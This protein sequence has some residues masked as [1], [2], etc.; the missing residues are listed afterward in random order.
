MLIQARFKFDILPKKQ[1]TKNKLVEFTMVAP[2]KRKTKIRTNTTKT[3]NCY[4][5]D[6]I[7]FPHSIPLLT[8]R[9]VTAPDNLSPVKPP[10]TEHTVIEAVEEH[11]KSD[12]HDTYGEDAVTNIKVST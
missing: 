6:P 12:E 8:T 1:T 11:S 7:L 5:V 3:L 9:P 10:S 4:N 2:K